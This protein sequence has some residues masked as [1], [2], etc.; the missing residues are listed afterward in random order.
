MKGALRYELN[1]KRLYLTEEAQAMLGLGNALNRGG[2]NLGALQEGVRR[3][4]Y[5]VQNVLEATVSTNTLLFD[6]SSIV[7]FYG[8]RERLGVTFDGGNGGADYA[9]RLRNLFTRNRIGTN[10]GLLGGSLSLGYIMEYKR[11]SASGGGAE[12]KWL[13]SYWLHTLEPQY[14]L[15]LP[16]GTL[17]LT[18]PLEYISY[19][20]PRRG[21]K[22]R[23]V[24]FSPMLDIDYR[25]GTMATIDL[26]I[27]VNRNAD[28]RTT[29]FGD[30]MANNYR[31]VTLGTD[32]MSFSRTAMA[33]ARLSW[34]NTA[35]MLSW[36]V[37]VGWQQEKADRHYSYLYAGD[38]TVIMPVWRDNRRTSWSA[39]ANVKKVF[40]STRLTLRGTCSYSYNKALASQNGTEGY[41]RYSA[42]ARRG[43]NW[44][45]LRPTSPARATLRGNAATFSR[46]RTTP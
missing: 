12:G 5:Y 25:L 16:G 3:R 44:A 20:S 27:G 41:L 46:P 2:S 17:T 33:G 6:V 26:N 23:K 21:V 40:R 15:T 43:T 22:T 4:Q 30:A 9:V 42:L 36:N 37:Y 35:T 31:T 24:M 29:P 18:L 39:A 34:L 11:N 13:S 19:S 32:S 28:T 8:S 1:S 7:R 38:M 45:G 10:F 14:E